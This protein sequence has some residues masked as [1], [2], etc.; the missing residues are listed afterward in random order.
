MRREINFLMTNEDLYIWNISIFV[1]SQRNKIDIRSKSAQWGPCVFN[2]GV[3]SETERR[4]ESTARGGGRHIAY[5]AGFYEFDEFQ[6][7]FL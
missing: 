3:H 4:I 1:Q 2:M 7:F 6:K 5:R